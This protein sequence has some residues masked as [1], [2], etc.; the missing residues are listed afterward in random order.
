MNRITL[1][2]GLILIFLSPDKY[3]RS[4]AGFIDTVV[5]GNPGN[6]AIDI[7][8][9]DTRWFKSGQ[10]G[11]VSYTYR[12]GTTEVTNDQYVTFLNAVA[13]ADPRSLFHSSMQSN[14][15][16]GILRTGTSGNYSY[17]SK[18]MM[19]DK[20]VNY[21]N[22]W[23]AKRFTNWLHNGMPS[24]SQDLTTTEDGAY[25][26]GGVTNPVDRNVPRRTDARWFLPTEDEWFKAAYHKN[27][28]VTGNYFEYPTGTD[29]VPIR[30]IADAFGNVANPGSNVVNY[31][32]AADWNGLNGNVTTVGSAT[33]PS[34]YGTLDQAGN[35]DEWN[36]TLI[37]CAL[38]VDGGCNAGPGPD[39]VAILRGGTWAQPNDFHI[40]GFPNGSRDVGGGENVIVGFRVA[41]AFEESADFNLDTLV[42]ETDLQIWQEGYG[43]SASGDADGDGDSDGNDFLIWQRQL[44]QSI[45]QTSH[46]AE[47]P[48][49]TTCSLLLS[50]VG[51]SVLARWNAR[52]KSEY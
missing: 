20:P 27:D 3:Q 43:V 40:V 23:D 14:A 28:G 31:D 50:I 6:T 51:F 4:E 44:T 10:F 7:V 36:D 46:S 38:L 47:I 21:V 15:R 17:S 29:E 16:G 39:M 24:G 9:G 33:S 35:L 12:I 48:E 42:D 22:F 49:P 25:F 19:G 11:A 41:A 8:P 5:I 26:L 30:A 2:A 32:N 13:A 45:S 1:A 52:G 34:A 37:G 18:P